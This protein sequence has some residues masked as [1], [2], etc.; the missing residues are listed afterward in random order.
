MT[1]RATVRFDAERFRR[2]LQTQAAQQARMARRAANEL[3]WRGRQAIQDEMRR[4]FDR[5]TRWTLNSMRIIHATDDG[6]AAVIDWKD[7]LY[8]R[9]GS[10]D[11]AQA[12]ITYLTPQIEGGTR[13]LK[14]FERVLREA[15]ILPPG[16]FVVPARFAPLDSSGNLRRASLV[17]ILSSVRAFSEVGFTANRSRDR[18]SRGVMRRHD[19]FAIRGYS[20]AVK[21]KPGI[22]LRGQKGRR[23]QMV[24]AFVK[25]PRYRARLAPADVVRRVVAEQSAEVWSLA[26]RRAL[27]FRRAG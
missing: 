27:P 16:M 13:P 24:L 7:L 2:E 26:Q 19:Y 6:G 17:K 3:A 15:G 21:L 4:V 8:V 20:N 18:A 5:P 22:Y 10:Q 25:Q 12:A 23:P 14:R 11:N 9:G 1:L